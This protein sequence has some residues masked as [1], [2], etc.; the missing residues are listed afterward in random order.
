MFGK[1]N[2]EQNVITCDNYGKLLN[3]PK[4]IAVSAKIS[5][6]NLYN[7]IQNNY[8]NK[9]KNKLLMNCNLYLKYNYKEYLD[10]INQ[11]ILEY[12]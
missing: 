2:S 9:N 12:N 1:I 11:Y 10:I 6:E 4:F 8:K 5:E 7:L 3:N